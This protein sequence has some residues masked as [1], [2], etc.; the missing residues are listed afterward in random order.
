MENKTKVHNYFTDFDVNLFR[1]G[2]HF[3][4]YEKFGAHPMEVDGEKGVYFAVY[5]P[6]ADRVRVVGSFNGWIGEGYDL[7]VRWDSSGIWE[8]FAPGLGEGE[9]YKFEIFSTKDGRIRHKADPYAFKTELMP[10]SASIIWTSKH[11]W[12]DKKWMTKGRAEKNQHESPFAVYEVHLGSWK[13]NGTDSLSY[14]ELGKDLVDYVKEMGFTHVEMMPIT[15]H[16]YY[17][18]W[19]Y[20]STSYFAPTSR[21]GDPDELKFLVDSFH[22]AGIGVLVDWVPA[23]FPNDEFALADFDGSCVYEHFDR[24][25]GFHPDWNSLIFNFERNE[26]RSFLIS[27]AFYW[28]EHFHFDGLRVDAVSSMLYLDYSRDEGQWSPNI[29]GGNEYLAA[30]D[31]LRDLNIAIYGTFPNVQMI[32]EESTAFPG[33]TKPAHTGGLGFGKKWM[34]GWMNDTLEYFSRDPIY[35]KYHHNEIS[36]SMTYAFTEN[37][38]L[39]LSHDEVVHGKGSIISRMP[40]DDWQQFANLRLLYSYMYTHPGDKLLFMGNEIGQRSEWNFNESLEWFVLDYTLHKG[41]QQLVKDLNQLYVEESALNEKNFSPDGFEW[42]SYDDHQNSVLSYVR[43]SEDE[44]VLVIC[45]FTPNV[46]HGYKI[47]V[48]GKGKYKVL[49]NTDSVKYGGSGSSKKR[50]YSTIAEK[51]HGR[52]YSLEM[53]LAPLG[54][55]ILKK[56]KK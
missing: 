4:L 35:R 22:K 38:M 33:V 12:K 2:K 42:I 29:F 23:H 47:G 18:S 28:F 21:Y 10:K 27:S 5:A 20:L 36:F 9:M 24:Q 41:I 52:E 8:G 13:K 25:K 48:P 34:M 37:F 31:F 56:E 6:S 15:E 1:A 26:I 50:V 45:N 16:P 19:G 11:K 43:K 40:G 30:K 55:V 49:L 32:A 7:Y 53:S 44:S 14:K 51:S 46:L 54:T 39:P 3:K 17:P